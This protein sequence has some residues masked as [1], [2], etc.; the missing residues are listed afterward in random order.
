MSPSGTDDGGVVP[1]FDEETG[2]LAI[3]RA[4]IEV[5]CLL[6]RRDDELLGLFATELA[7]AVI[8]NSNSNEKRPLLLTLG[9]RGHLEPQ[10]LADMKALVE[11]VRVW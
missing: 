6:G 10:H 5:D 11:Q 8:G 2:E 3:K 9:L 1:E 4:H 7:D